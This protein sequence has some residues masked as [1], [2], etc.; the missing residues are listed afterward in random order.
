MLAC[1]F[2][3]YLRIVFAVSCGVCLGTLYC[4]QVVSM[5]NQINNHIG[6]EVILTAQ[7]TTKPKYADGE[8]SFAVKHISYQDEKRPTSGQAYVKIVQTRVNYQRNDYI[9]LRGLQRKGFGNYDAYFW[10]PTIMIHS[11]P[12][13]PDFGL[14][15]QESIQQHLNERLDIE[16]ASLAVGYLLGDKT[17]MPS[18]LNERLSKA[19]LSHVVVASGFALGVI[20]SFS[21]KIFQ[22][23]S[24]F[25]STIF[26]AILIVIFIMIIGLSPSLIRASIATFLALLTG[27]F[28]RRLHPMRSLCYI[29]SISAWYSPADFCSAA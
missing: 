12:R 11:Q 8:V 20:A 29:A 10:R 28:G 2:K 9:V 19:G 6:K 27:Y 18:S 1:I 7:I 26:S 17:T 25:A 22:R 15:I 23:F 21:R 14:T 13:S 4:S 3:K 5:R 24:R 16:Q